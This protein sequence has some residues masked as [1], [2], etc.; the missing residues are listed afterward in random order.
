MPFGEIPL[1]A[2]G[3]RGESPEK[4]L[5][6]TVPPRATEGYHFLLA[7]LDA[8]DEIAETNERDNVV[9]ESLRVLSP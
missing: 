9:L 7:V 8:G 5:S 6:V 2:I 1:G 3:V 4:T